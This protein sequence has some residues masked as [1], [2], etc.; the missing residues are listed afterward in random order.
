MLYC[1]D[2]NRNAPLRFLL[3]DASLCD[4]VLLILLA[5]PSDE[6]EDDA[7]TDPSTG[8]TL[9]LLVSANSLL[10]AS[11]FASAANTRA[12]PE[13]SVRRP[14]EAEVLVV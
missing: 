11:T 2:E 5:R 8:P 9:P 6:D 4:R 3:K 7:D 13:K 10:S 1:L 14:C 12:R